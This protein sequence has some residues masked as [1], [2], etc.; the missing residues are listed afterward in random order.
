MTTIRKAIEILER[1]KGH[2]SAEEA[3]ALQL[4]LEVLQT[5]WKQRKAAMDVAEHMARK[6]AEELFDGDIEKG[7][8]FLRDKFNLDEQDKREVERRLMDETE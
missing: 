3:E 7:W 4:A 8:E 5:E 6:A 1:M 2:A